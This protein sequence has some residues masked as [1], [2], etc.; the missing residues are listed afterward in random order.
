MLR[1]IAYGSE[2]N[3]AYP[4]RP[5]DAL[6]AWEPEWAAKIR[7]KSVLSAMLGME[8]V[9]QPAASDRDSGSQPGHD[10]ED[11]GGND[12]TVDGIGQSINKIRGI[13]GF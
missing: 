4:P 7:V 6:V 5:D 1:M 9:M 8:E 2:L 12:A 3:L 10:N 13:F 11:K